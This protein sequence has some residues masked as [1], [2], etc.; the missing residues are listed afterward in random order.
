VVE[1]SRALD[2]RLSEWCCSVSSSL[3]HLGDTKSLVRFGTLKK[4]TN[5][6][7]YININSNILTE[8]SVVNILQSIIVKNV[9]KLCLSRRSLI[10]Y[11]K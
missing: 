6:T 8:E 9:K 7:G 5:L 1:W 3:F 2:V 4:L 11:Y 10:W